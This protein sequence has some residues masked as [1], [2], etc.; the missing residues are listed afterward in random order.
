VLTD[1]ISEEESSSMKETV[2][3]FAKFG[4]RQPLHN[5]LFPGWGRIVRDGRGTL[6]YQKGSLK[7]MKVTFLMER[8]AFKRDFFESRTEGGVEGTFKVLVIEIP[9]E[10]LL[11]CRLGSFDKYLGKMRSVEGLL[12]DSSWTQGV[13]VVELAPDDPLHGS[14]GQTIQVMAQSL[15]QD[16]IQ[17]EMWPLRISDIKDSYNMPTLSKH[18]LRLPRIPEHREPHRLTSPIVP[19]MVD[20]TKIQNDEANPHSITVHIEASERSIFFLRIWDNETTQVYAEGQL[21]D[22]PDSWAWPTFGGRKCF[23]G[24]KCWSALKAF[25]TAD[26]RPL[27]LDIEARCNEYSEPLK[28]TAQTDYQVPMLAPGPPEVSVHLT[29]SSIFEHGKLHFGAPRDPDTKQLPKYYA[30]HRFRIITNFPPRDDD[31]LDEQLPK[32]IFECG[33]PEC[34]EGFSAE[35]EVKRKD[36]PSKAVG[37]KEKKQPCYEMPV[38]L[39]MRTSTC[40]V[41]ECVGEAQVFNARA[42]N[43]VSSERSAVSM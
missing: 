40:K 21:K 19:F 37:C 20:I 43:W 34:L 41:L 9:Y 3:N 16:W 10:C 23:A 11:P 36:V 4:L 33:G 24:A 5:S 31:E 25:G 42:G 29:D 27:V 6:A 2:A 35:V 18:V 22:S 28:A 17:K 39:R 7:R 32:V 1:E 8:I 26:G 30:E 15:L 13:L 38:L 14:E 12:D